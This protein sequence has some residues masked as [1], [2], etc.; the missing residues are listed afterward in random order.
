MNVRLVIISML[1]WFWLAAVSCRAASLSIEIENP[2]LDQDERWQPYT[3]KL[4][5]RLEAAWQ[6][7]GSP[8][9]DARVLVELRRN[10]EIVSVAIAGS[11]GDRNFDQSAVDAVR[12]IAPF[13]AGPQEAPIRLRIVFNHLV[14]A[15]LAARAMASPA[16]PGTA[17]QPTLNGEP[18][19]KG[20]PLQGHVDSLGAAISAN[21][22]SNQPGF[23]TP[24]V[25]AG[26]AA[27][28]PLMP[29]MHMQAQK[30][31][32]GTP[33]IP[34]WKL[35]AGYDVL[36]GRFYVAF[37]AVDNPPIPIVLMSMKIE[38]YWHGAR[39]NPCHI[40]LF[41]VHDGSGAYYFVCMENRFGPCGW[42][43]PQPKTEPGAR[44][45]AIYYAQPTP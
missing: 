45:W 17:E 23:A 20:G 12:N 26:V 7:S 11:S 34:Q 33:R 29:P 35:D 36:L 19:S 8:S 42:L 32:S 4:S 1:L 5:N 31:S 40:H 25:E 37:I 15:E 6:P 39:P 24:E 18:P 21:Q 44:Q 13:P 9:G 43:L 22:Q 14:A 27:S 30:D 2:Q 3:E 38:R 28:E 10:G 16:L 41:K